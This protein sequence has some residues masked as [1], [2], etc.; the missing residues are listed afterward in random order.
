[1]SR[2]EPVAAALP[3]VIRHA[4]CPAMPWKNG[5]GSTTEVAVFPPGS[6]LD[7]FDWRVSMAQVASDGPFS[8]FPGI[9]RSLAILD[10]AGL[11]LAIGDAP[12]L[13]L[14][15]DKAPLAF[16]ADAPTQAWL[17]DGPVTDLNVMTRRG[18]FR[19]ALRRL[20]LAAGV[21]VPVEGSLAM[22][23]ALSGAALRVGGETVHLAA[24]DTLVLAPSD[25]PA[26][27]TLVP[28]TLFR[29]DIEAA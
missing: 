20:V 14:A 5:G 6:G 7:T 15:G 19:H 28:C 13:D 9:D 23:V 24:R 21:P 25:R 11:R 4:D 12:A 17:L 16:P 8:L 18:R 2:D 29:L 22:L 27:E 3:R 10:G 26:A 1:M